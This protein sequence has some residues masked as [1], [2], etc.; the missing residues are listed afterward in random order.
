MAIAIIEAWTNV[1]HGGI[2][3]VKEGFTTKAFGD[4]CKQVLT[5]SISPCL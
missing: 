3:S 5:E 2:V 1:H 4:I